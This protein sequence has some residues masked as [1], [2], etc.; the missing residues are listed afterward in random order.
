[1]YVDS[2]TMTA[3][4]LEKVCI[5]ALRLML[6][7]TSSKRMHNVT[8]ED[9]LKFQAKALESEFMSRPLLFSVYICRMTTTM[10]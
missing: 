1:V 9:L 8:H 6:L 7:G 2:V 4:E 10:A 3:A 5:K